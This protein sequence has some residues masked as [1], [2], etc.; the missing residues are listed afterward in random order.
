MEESIG[1]GSLISRW[2]T[3]SKDHYTLSFAKVTPASKSDTV[4][5]GTTAIKLGAQGER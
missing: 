2:M 4:L 5:V 1:L 3:E